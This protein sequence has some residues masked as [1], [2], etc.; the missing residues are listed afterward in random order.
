MSE[1][2][3][4]RHAVESWERAVRGWRER[5]AEPPPTTSVPSTPVAGASAPGGR[6]RTPAGH[7]LTLWAMARSLLLGHPRVSD[8]RGHHRRL[9]PGV[10]CFFGR[11]DW[12]EKSLRRTCKRCGRV[13]RQGKNIYGEAHWIVDSRGAA[14]PLLASWKG[15]LVVGGPIAIGTMLVA[16][17]WP[18]RN[19]PPVDAAPPIQFAGVQW[20]VKADP[21]LIGPGPNYFAGNNVLVDDEGRLRLRIVNPNASK[22][23]A[24]RA[25]AFTIRVNV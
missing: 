15:R 5:E 3:D 20:T 10:G 21:D 6:R 13:E 24:A 4:L 1:P 8:R 16:V 23:Q 18:S 11:H 22:T 7:I 14:S 19:A 9:G 2:E 12:S 25:K 17:A